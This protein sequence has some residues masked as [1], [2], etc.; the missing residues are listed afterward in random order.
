M[1]YRVIDASVV[2]AKMLDEERPRWVDA[3]ITAARYDELD[4]IAPT[5]LWVEVGNRLVR[6][7][8]TDE[9]AL[10]AMLRVEAIGIEAVELQP[11]LRLRAVQLGREHQLS[12][13]DATYLAIAE[14]TLAPLLTLDADLEQ[15]AESIGLGRSGRGRVSEPVARY[16]DDRPVDQVSIAAIGAALAEMRRQYAR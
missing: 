11:P 4:L 13:Y 16:G 7:D 10:D 15:A 3:A 12:M 1:T 14:S 8:M 5:L 2:I 9:Q 6:R